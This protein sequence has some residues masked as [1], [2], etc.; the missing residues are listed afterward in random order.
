MACVPRV[1][2]AGTTID[3]ELSESNVLTRTRNRSRLEPGRSGFG[4]HTSRGQGTWGCAECLLA[5]GTPIEIYMAA[6][7]SAEI[8]EVAR[9][10][11]SGEQASPVLAASGSQERP[12]RQ[13]YSAAPHQAPLRARRTA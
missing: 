10:P 8:S 3:A 1:M 13:Y 4:A 5:I 6:D 9:L 11:L 12:R 2:E 7:L